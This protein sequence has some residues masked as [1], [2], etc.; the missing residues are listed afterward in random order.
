LYTSSLESDPFCIVPV[1]I[2]GDDVTYSEVIGDRRLNRS[3]KWL[4]R[5]IEF[6]VGSQRKPVQIEPSPRGR[7]SSRELQLLEHLIVNPSRYRQNRHGLPTH[8]MQNGQLFVFLALQAVLPTRQRPALLLRRSLT[9]TSEERPMR[10]KFEEW[11]TGLL[12][13]LWHRVE[14]RALDDRARTPQWLMKQVSRELR[15]MQMEYMPREQP[16]NFNHLVPDY[17]KDVYRFAK[18]V[19]KKAKGP[20]LK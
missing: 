20:S 18:S 12:C 11:E 3:D 4:N 16:T 10:S 8:A 7:L 9:N 13:Q 19:L 2:A 17:D 15:H 14:L 1:E 6:E 5:S